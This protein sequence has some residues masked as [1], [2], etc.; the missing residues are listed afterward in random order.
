MSNAD[1]VTK[2]GECWSRD[3][4]R[5]Y[6]DFC[7][8]LDMEGDLAPGDT[9]YRG[10]VKRYTGADLINRF[11]ASSIT[12]WMGEAAYDIVGE[13][14]DDYPNVSDEAKAE[15]LAL[16]KGWADKHATPTWWEAVDPRE[17][18][19]AAAYLE[20]APAEGQP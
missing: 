2:P 10:T 13:V 11:A 19:L 17:Y 16:L 20:A 8:F 7:E 9:V 15:L 18:V 14:A 4:E 3:G 5:Y 12:D 6:D 1:E